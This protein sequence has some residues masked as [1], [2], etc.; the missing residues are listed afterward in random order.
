MLG[1]DEAAIAKMSAQ[2]RREQAEFA[3]SLLEEQ[4]AADEPPADRGLEALLDRLDAPRRRL[5]LGSR[6][7]WIL[8]GP[9]WRPCSAPPGWGIGF[10]AG[11]RRRRETTTRVDPDELTNWLEWTTEYG[12]SQGAWIEIESPEPWRGWAQVV[13]HDGRELVAALVVEIKPGATLPSSGLTASALKRVRVAGALERLVAQP[14]AALKMAR[15]AAR[16]LRGQKPPPL[17]AHKGVDFDAKLAIEY[18]E[19]CEVDPRAPYRAM[20]EA[21]RRDGWDEQSIK[22]LPDQV[23][24]LRERG[25]LTS[26]PN[27]VAGGSATRKLVAW[28]RESTDPQIRRWADSM[29]LI[30]EED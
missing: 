26:T 5:G 3:M 10:G 12:P 16:R 28:A 17:R 11:R 30:N 1:F 15:V 6:Y 24:R 7:P 25:F 23:R 18:L 2:D 13:E 14:A 21:R 29:G 9:G 27:G 22:R 19:A 4:V 8:S 20:A